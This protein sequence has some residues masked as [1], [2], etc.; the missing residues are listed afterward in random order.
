MKNLIFSILVLIF[1]NSYSQNGEFETYSN[2]LIYSASTMSKLSQI[3]DSL[4]LKYKSCDFDKVFKAKSQTIG[5]VI[6]LKSKNIKQ[7]KKDIENQIAFEAFIKKYPN[8]EIEKEVLIV[9]FKYKNYKGKDIVEFSEVSPNDD[10]GLEI[11]NHDNPAI[12]KQKMK[13]EWIYR[14]HKKSDYSEESISAF[15]FPNEFTSKPLN[16]K[17]G[18]MIGYSDCLIDTTAIKFKENAKTGWVDL[19]KNW[20][21]LSKKRKNKLLDQMRETKVVGGCSMDSRPREHAANIAVLSAETTKWEI[22]LRSHLDIMNDRFDRVSDGSYAWEG[23]KTYIR[24]LEELDINVLNLIFGISLR[25]ENPAK[26]HYYGSISRIGRALSETKNSKEIETTM[27]NMIEDSELDDYNRVLSY[28]LFLNYN[29]YIKNQALKKENLN[30]LKHSVNLLPNYL[31]S[32]I[33]L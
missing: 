2:G 3:V 9:K 16:Q 28:F 33:I 6:K 1:F 27:L 12:Y 4:N 21:K 29:H 13:G 11:K 22:F 20:K 8:A 5:H 7:A 10:Y 32:K 23:R 25:V 15:Y 26:N 17:Y 31:K 19:P 24:E 30:K 18:V 14:Y